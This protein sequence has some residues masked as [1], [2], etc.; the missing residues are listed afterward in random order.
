VAHIGLALTPIRWSV[1]QFKGFRQARRAAK[2]A[3]TL[4]AEP[5]A[6]IRVR[7]QIAHADMGK[8][9]VFSG[10]SPRQFTHRVFSRSKSA[11]ICCVDKNIV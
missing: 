11:R 2:R 8:A 3:V 6:Q 5:P 1:D 7:H 4:G 9:V 10:Y